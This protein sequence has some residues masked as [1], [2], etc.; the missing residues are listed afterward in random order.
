MGSDQLSVRS[1]GI[2]RLKP[3]VINISRQS[4]VR[5]P[6]GNSLDCRFEKYFIS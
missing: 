4:L 5:S 6:E 1:L 2:L 3:R